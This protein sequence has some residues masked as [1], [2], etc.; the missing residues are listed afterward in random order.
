MFISYKKLSEYILTTTY[1]YAIFL[2]KVLFFWEIYFWSMM[3]TCSVH[4]HM[5]NIF[6]F[7]FLLVNRLLVG[8][9][10]FLLTRNLSLLRLILIRLNY[11]KLNLIFN[12]WIRELKIN[13]LHIPR[14]RAKKLDRISSLELYLHT[15]SKFLRN[16]PLWAEQARKCICFR[17]VVFF[18]KFILVNTQDWFDWKC[19]KVKS[20]SDYI[21][22]GIR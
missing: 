22:F 17:S 13:S 9:P 7:W 1:F 5:I 18:T 16:F 8:W 11:L 3:T 4:I 21:V 15:Y 2:E 12:S 10:S 19:L 14:K 20:L 6:F